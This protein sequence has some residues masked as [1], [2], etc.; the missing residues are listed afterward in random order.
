MS[1]LDLFT[2]DPN[3]TAFAEKHGYL[4][5][6]PSPSPS[7]PVA[8]DI[9]SDRAEQAIDEAKWSQDHPLSSVGYESLLSTIA[10]RDGT[11]ISVKLSFPTSSRLAKTKTNS[12]SNSNSKLPIL[13]VTH[14]GGWVQGTH[15]TEEAWLLWPLYPAFDMLIVSV[16]YRMAPEHPFPAWMDDSWDILDKL[17]SEPATFLSHFHLSSASGSASSSHSSRGGAHPGVDIDIDTDKVILL[18]SSAGAGTAAYLSQ[19]CRDKSIPNIYGVVLNVPLLCDYRHL[20]ADCQSSYEQVTT[21]L[22]SAG[23]MRAEWDVV[24]PSPTAG[25]NPKASPLLGDVKG[26]PRHLVFVAGQD[27]LRD[28]GLKY[29][30]NLEE[31]GVEVKLHTYPGVPHTFAEFWELDATARFW[32]DLRSGLKAWLA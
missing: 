11:A 12:N 24:I 19:T 10:V 21:S 32:E 13:F 3:W 27:P 7:L 23:D 14:G 16:E 1:K 9:P 30:Q 2:S 6:T 29:A 26:L 15:I 25:K 5:P 20:P 17:L 4:K 31:A 8:L 28:E 22:L 18:G